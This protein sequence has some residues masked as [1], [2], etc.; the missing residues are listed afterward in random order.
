MVL[1]LL[2]RCLW[3]GTKNQADLPDA[4]TLETMEGVLR[5]QTLQLVEWLEA[6]RDAIREG[7]FAAADTLLTNASTGFR[8]WPFY[9]VSPE[10]PQWLSQ[11]DLLNNLKD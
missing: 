4:K 9:R 7:D 8:D 3:L 5:E 2:G 6:A 1:N 11:E 10:N